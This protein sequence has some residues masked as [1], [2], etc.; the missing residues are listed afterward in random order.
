MKRRTILVLALSALALFACA[1]PSKP[2]TDRER[3]NWGFVVHY[4]LTF[5]AETKRGVEGRTDSELYIFGKGTLNARNGGTNA[6]GGS[7]YQSFPKWVRVTW[8]QGDFVLGNNGWKGGT[9]VGDYTVPVLERIPE[10]VFA[11]V[12]AQR[13]RVIRLKF[14]IHDEGV[15]F[16]WDVQDRGKDRKGPIRHVMAGGDW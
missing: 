2:Q 12:R 3:R 4:K 15:L 5:G 6:Y 9:I 13:G 8:R 10:E 16:G 7:R 14:S 11:Y 1:S